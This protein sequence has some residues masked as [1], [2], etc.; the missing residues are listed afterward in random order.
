MFHGNT[1]NDIKKYISVDMYRE[2]VYVFIFTSILKL[3][4]IL[5]FYANR[6]LSNA[7]VKRRKRETKQTLEV[8]YKV[9]VLPF[10]TDFGNQTFTDIAQETTKILIHGTLENF[11]LTW[12]NVTESRMESEIEK[13]SSTEKRDE[14][15]CGIGYYLDNITCIS[16]CFGFKCENDGQCI[17]D[18]NGEALCRCTQIGDFVVSGLNCDIQTEKLALESKFI[19]AITSTVGIILNI[20][21]MIT[22]FLYYLKRRKVKSMTKAIESG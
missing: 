18:K 16:N 9:V 19:I 3:I 21:I 20:V 1:V 22:C 13:Q 10:N 15:V 14:L 5:V 12:T 8:G 2:Y 4:V 11:D 17:I 6:I 7:P